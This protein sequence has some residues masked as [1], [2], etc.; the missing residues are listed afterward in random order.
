MNVRNVIKV[1]NFHS[2]LRVDKARKDAEKYFEVEKE[3]RKMIAS[4]TNNRNYI[5]DK[6][7]FTIDPNKPILNI[8]IGSDLGFCGAYNFN[9]N[10]VAKK[11]HDSDKVLIGKRVWRNAKNVKLHIP[12]NDYLADR[13]PVTDFI[14]KAII[15]RKY[16]E[17]NVLYN[18]Y[19]NTSSINWTKKTLYPLDMDDDFREMKFT[20]DFVSESDIDELLINMI[21][22]Y[23]DYE[24]LII[25]K[26]S[27]ASEN[28]LRQNSTTESLK[29]LDE[30]EEVKAN[31][32]YKEKMAVASQKTIENFVKL[33]AAGGNS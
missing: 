30:I 3:L 24:I 33:K 7:I 28:I 17:I 9:V 1:M 20:E 25:M 2:L 21:S 23:V 31:A 5:L 19:E 22:T 11:D 15:Q 4:I 8:Y 12:K 29:K 10:E 16:S 6:K 27:L 14:E 18:S 13:K 32:E 26:N